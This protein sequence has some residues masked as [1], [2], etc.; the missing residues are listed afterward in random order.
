LNII[1][2][3]VLRYNIYIGLYV[4]GYQDNHPP[5]FRFLAST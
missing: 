4:N 5:W 3:I 1:Y 2:Y